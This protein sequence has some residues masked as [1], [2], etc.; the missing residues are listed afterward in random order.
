MKLR[1]KLIITSL[2]FGAAPLMA[3][4]GI[5]NLRNQRAVET[6]VG[7]QTQGIA[8]RVSEE[9]GE[10]HDLRRGDLLFLAE[11]TE[12]LRLLGSGNLPPAFPNSP[13]PVE[14]LTQAWQ[15]LRGPFRW[16]QFRDNSGE[17]L[18]SLGDPPTEGLSLADPGSN[19]SYNSDLILSEIIRD[20]ASGLPLGSVSAALHPP[21]VFPVDLEDLGFGARGWVTI[22]NGETGRTLSPPT[23]AMADPALADLLRTGSWLSEGSGSL[24]FQDEPWIASI[25][26]VAGTPWEVVSAAALLEFSQ[27]FLGA[28]RANFFL[29]IL[30]TVAVSGALVIITL[31]TTRSLV[32]LTFA[33]EQVAGGNLAPLLPPPGDDEAGTL[34]KAFR[35]MLDHIQLMIRQLEESRQ[36]AAVGEFSAQIT[37]ELRNP[38][39][40]IRMSIQGLSRSLAD[41]EHARPLEIALQETERLERVTQGVLSLGRRSPGSPT[42]VEVARLAEMGVQAV[43]PELEKLGI[44]I[45]LRPPSRVLKVCVVEEAL[46]GALINLLRN[47][48]EA[49]PEGGSVSLVIEAAQSEML[50]IHIVDEG[51]GIDPE[52]ASHI[53]DPFVTSKSKGNGFG[54]PLALK[55]AEEAG[56]TLFLVENSS[57]K[58]AHF[59]LRLPIH[60][61]E[62][63][64]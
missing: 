60:T 31:R 1:T 23:R 61:V 7:A 26:P 54:L 17:V 11:N 56:G 29:V 44:A 9:I 12:T 45:T 50:D 48:A 18:V 25:V 59:V 38:L 42:I 15:V 33:A 34:T 28:A 64:V 20:L 52:I 55:A 41:T 8:R 22:V 6:F 27:P 32:S 51:P 3:V 13:D 49:M 57:D 19:L 40:A 58:G 63:D 10:R 2:V 62:V 5:T 24:L 30:I 43:L 53:F 39:T 16:V 36:L 4:G 47:S 37:H 14:F 21:S 35:V 46:R